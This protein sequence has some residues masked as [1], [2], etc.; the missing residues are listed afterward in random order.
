MDKR[1]RFTLI[2][3][4]VVIAIIAI[5]A[6]M[7]LPALNKAREKAHRTKCL[8]NY[9]Q[10][11]LAVAQYAQDNADWIPQINQG[12]PWSGTSMDPYTTSGFGGS[13]NYWSVSNGTV[14]W[15]NPANILGLGFLVVGDYIPRQFADGEA[16]K[17]PSLILCPSM[18]TWPDHASGVS[19][20]YYYIGGLQY[21][22]EYCRNPDGKVRPRRRITDKSDCVITFDYV[23]AHEQYSNALYLGGHAMSRKLPNGAWPLVGASRFYAVVLED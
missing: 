15:K 11:G 17:T 23:A 14:G 13:P 16:P 20:G 6:A 4:L 1:K 18:K 19:T 2:E 10:I 7:L 22:P 5:L 3:L 12:I 9:K 21:T 8:S